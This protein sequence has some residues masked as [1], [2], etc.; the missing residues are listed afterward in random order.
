MATTE[1]LQQRLAEAER[2]YHALMT[3]KTVVEFRDSNGENLKYNQSSMRS[4]GM[5]IESLKRQLGLGSGLGPMGA[6]F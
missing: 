1:E 6:T 2:A 3:G 4:L 5:Y